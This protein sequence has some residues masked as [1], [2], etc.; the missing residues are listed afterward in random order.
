MR[1]HTHT[2]IHTCS[3]VI[4]SAQ[5]CPFMVGNYAKSGAYVRTQTPY[6]IGLHNY[7]ANKEDHGMVYKQVCPSTAS[8]QTTKFLF[9]CFPPK[10]P[11]CP[12]I[13]FRTLHPA[14]YHSSGDT[15]IM[16]ALWERI[17]DQSALGH[18]YTPT[19]SFILGTVY[20]NKGLIA[21]H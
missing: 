2:D 19:L 7:A 16:F 12:T 17:R 5:V 20:W 4:S 18:L 21:P 3:M 8:N 14:S 9:R 6:K 1:K 10:S 15:G 11:T 13:S